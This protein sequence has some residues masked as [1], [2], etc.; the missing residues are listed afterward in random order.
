M[1]ISHIIADHMTQI[2]TSYPRNEDM[3]YMA[4]QPVDTCILDHFGYCKLCICICYNLPT[5]WDC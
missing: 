5:D 3:G 2:P 1:S 4:K